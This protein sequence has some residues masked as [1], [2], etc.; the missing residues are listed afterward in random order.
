MDLQTVFVDLP[1]PY[2]PLHLRVAS[3]SQ[4]SDLP[5]PSELISS[6]TYLATRSSS[7]LPPSTRLASLRHDPSSSHPISLTLKVRLPGGKGGFGSQLRAAGGRMSS[8]KNN[9][10]DSC[11]DLSG[12]RLSTIKE[13]ER[14]ADLPSQSRADADADAQTSG[15]AGD[16]AGDARQPCRGRE[17]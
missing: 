5:F 2:A 4:L 6:H 14:Y 13:A 8:G 3:S 17:G 9:N 11:R 7:A 1:S 12:R 15:A 16:H 10:T